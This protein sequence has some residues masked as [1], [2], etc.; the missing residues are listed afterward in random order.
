L[1]GQRA[2]LNPKDIW[3]ICIHPSNAHHVR[4]LAMVN[5]AIDSKL[6]ECDLVC[7]RVRDVTHGNQVLSID[8]QAQPVPDYEFALKFLFVILQ[9]LEP[10]GEVVDQRAYG[11]QQAAARRIHD[12]NDLA[13]RGPIGQEGDESAGGQIVAQH[14]GRKLNDADTGAR[15]TA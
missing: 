6:R 8:P 2:P 1:V 15:C 14:Q 7:L 9:C 13:W 10:L 3:A 4:D 11:G 5:L 12:V